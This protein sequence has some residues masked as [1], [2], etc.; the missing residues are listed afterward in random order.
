MEERAWFGLG[1]GSWEFADITSASISAIGFEDKPV[2]YRGMMEHK[3]E[4]TIMGYKGIMIH[5]NYYNLIMG[6]LGITE[7]KMETTMMSYVGL[8]RGLTTSRSP[9]RL[10]IP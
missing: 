5:G 4:T 1:V 3:M 7:K 9:A 8:Y 10:L 6:Y 2:G